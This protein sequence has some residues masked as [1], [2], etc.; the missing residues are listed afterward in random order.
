MSFD[1][2]WTQ[3]QLDE[4]K[5]MGYDIDPKTHL[6]KN[7]PV[8]DK[9]VDL[10]THGVYFDRKTLQPFTH[11]KVPLRHLNKDARKVEEIMQRV[12]DATELLGALDDAERN[13]STAEIQ[14]ILLTFEAEVDRR[15]AIRD[16]EMELQVER[17][18][19]RID[20]CARLSREL[21][22]NET[23]IGDEYFA[24][25]RGLDRN[26]QWRAAMDEIEV[27]IRQVYETAVQQ[28]RPPRPA[29]TLDTALNRI[30]TQ[31]ADINSHLECAYCKCAFT[32]DNR[33]SLCKKNHFACETCRQ[34][35]V[36]EK[37]PCPCGKKV[38]A[39]CIYMRG[40]DTAH[41][42]AAVEKRQDLLGRWFTLNDQSGDK[43]D[44]DQWP[45]A[46]KDAQYAVSNSG[47]ETKKRRTMKLKQSSSGFDD[48]YFAELIGPETPPP[49]SEG[50]TFITSYSEKARAMGTTSLLTVL[51]DETSN[52][53]TIVATLRE[54]NVQTEHLKLFMEIE[55][56]FRVNDSMM[57]VFKQACSLIVRERERASAYAQQSTHG[58]S[59]F[60]TSENQ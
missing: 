26:P 53:A 60:L 3:E 6:V 56:L 37:K 43:L 47:P 1:Q 44:V 51:Q 23:V 58:V 54:L 35:M 40:V 7:P 19:R 39:R 5:A 50:V 8:A 9:P 13:Q 16:E 30:A 24:R 17:L 32:R 46:V 41:Y 20:F 29:Y 28:T 49:V 25:S 15:T 31:L 21:G 57:I 22:I 4:A 52:Y 36:R 14:T 11:A 45:V 38:T 2:S 18:S 55:T 59:H 42:I 27:E 48:A 33:I 10:K 34:Y 12:E